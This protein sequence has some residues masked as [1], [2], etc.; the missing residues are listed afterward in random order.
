MRRQSAPTNATPVAPLDECPHR[1]TH[2]QSAARHC[3]PPITWPSFMSRLERIRTIPVVYGGNRAVLF[4]TRSAAAPPDSPMRRPGSP[5][6]LTVRQPNP[7]QRLARVVRGLS[8]LCAEAQVQARNREAGAAYSADCNCFRFAA[9]ALNL[10]RNVQICSSRA[11]CS[12]PGGSLRAVSQSVA[13]IFSR[14][15]ILSQLHFA[16]RNTP[17]TTLRP[18]F[19]TV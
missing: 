15:C 12:A 5:G 13:A 19:M 14:S 16:V 9:T 8:A 2:L 17:K 7:H 1:D 10:V 3:H 18:L 6:L 4:E 11:C